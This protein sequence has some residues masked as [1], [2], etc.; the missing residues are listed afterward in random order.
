M[1]IAITE[2]VW[3]AMAEHNKLDQGIEVDIWSIVFISFQL[4]KKALQW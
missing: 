3:I 4:C 1:R 2:D